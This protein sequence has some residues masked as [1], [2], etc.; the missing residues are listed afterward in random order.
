MECFLHI[1]PVEVDVSSDTIDV[2]R[3]IRSFHLQELQRTNSNRSESSSISAPNPVLD[4]S[5][6]H[7]VFSYIRHLNGKKR[8][9]VTSLKETV[10]IH[11]IR[12]LSLNVNYWTGILR[13]RTSLTTYWIGPFHF[14]RLACLVESSSKWVTI[15]IDCT[16]RSVNTVKI[17]STDLHLTGIVINVVALLRTTVGITVVAS[18]A[19]LIVCLG[20]Y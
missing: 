5:R 11:I 2:T 15:G 12:N 1:F 10:P 3:I 13:K 8:T 19:Q 4:A 14:V 18:L 20:R 17:D 6:W 16:C 7:L 9:F